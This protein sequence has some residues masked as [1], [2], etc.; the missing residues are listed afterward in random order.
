MK[1]LTPFSPSSQKSTFVLLCTCSHTYTIINRKHLL[2]GALPAEQ[3]VH[4]NYVVCVHN[5]Y[6]HIVHVYLDISVLSM[7]A[8]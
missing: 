2:R 5:F 4:V 7:S 6:Q 1:K 3:S 8:M